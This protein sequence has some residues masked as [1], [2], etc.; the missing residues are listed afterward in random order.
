MQ[1]H[2]VDPQRLP[3]AQATGS[4][5]RYCGGLPA[6]GPLCP[7]T[8]PAADPSLLAPQALLAL[9]QKLEEV[10]VVVGGRAL[11]EEEEEGAEDLAP[12]AGNF[13][14]YH[15]KASEY[16]RAPQPWCRAS[17]VLEVGGC[18]GAWAPAGEGGRLR[19]ARRTPLPPAAALTLGFYALGPGESGPRPVFPVWES[20]HWPRRE[21]QLAAASPWHSCSVCLTGPQSWGSIGNWGV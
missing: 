6:P 18:R 13:A 20:G 16:P 15:T 17:S 5:R 9:P 11:E 7:R 12:Q 2:T 3:N 4:L 21:G 14:F 10:L 1:G 19:G 8:G